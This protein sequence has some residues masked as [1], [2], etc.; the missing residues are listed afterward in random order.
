VG[1]R[2]LIDKSKV[3]EGIFSE[4][5]ADYKYFVLSPEFEPN[6]ANFVGLVFDQTTLIISVATPAEYRP[7]IFAHEVICNIQLAGLRGRCRQALEAELSRVP[8]EI[9][10]G[11]VAFRL[12]FYEGLA[13]YYANSEDEEFKSEI[14]A[15][16]QHLQSL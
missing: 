6:L 14:Q 3:E 16:L 10:A 7:F 1:L 5:G 15:S 2:D 4:G 8:A 13:E 9:K 11:Y 12:R